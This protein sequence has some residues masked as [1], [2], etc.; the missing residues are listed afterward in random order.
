M[1]KIKISKM[2]FEDIDDVL[3]V[4]EESFPIPWSRKSFEDE[5]SNMFATYLVAKL[6]EKVVGFI[7]LWFIMDECHIT[8]IAVLKEYRNKH[9]A[10]KLV[11]EMFKSFKR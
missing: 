4:C 6:E 1:E 11:E 5:F 7:G 2:Q 8:N 3:K 10:T 9:V